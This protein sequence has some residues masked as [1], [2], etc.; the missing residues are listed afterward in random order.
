MTNEELYSRLSTSCARKEMCKQDVYKWLRKFQIPVE[1]HD[2]IIKRLIDENFIDEQRYSRAF[3]NDSLKYS[4]WGKTKISFM[5]H[6]KQIP[7]QFINNAISNLNT[8]LYQQIKEELR[9]AKSKTLDDD[10][11]QKEQKIQAYL[12]G[13]G[14]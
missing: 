9:A 5:L 1:L 12:Y 2:N 13:R 14:F 3:A 4:K 8:E 7:D 11:P 10:D 6:S